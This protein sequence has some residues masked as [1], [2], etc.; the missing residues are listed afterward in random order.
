MTG[1]E[2]GHAFVIFPK[3]N[4]LPQRKN[5]VE[6]TRPLLQ[7]IVATKTR[8]TI[9]KM[10][11]DAKLWKEVAPELASKYVKDGKVTKRITPE[12][13]K[14]IKES[15]R[16]YKY[17]LPNK[18][19]FPDIKQEKKTTVNKSTKDRCSLLRKIAN[20]EVIDDLHPEYNNLFLKWAI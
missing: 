16:N 1:K 20:Y 10:Q 9:E 13:A 8:P 18:H 5:I 2:Q 11:N 12:D 14:E 4:I 7:P 3:G 17:K 15:I 6:L 19:L